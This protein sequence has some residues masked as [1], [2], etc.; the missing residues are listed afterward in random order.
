MR[1]YPVEVRNECGTVKRRLLPIVACV[2]AIAPA[3]FAQ[4]AVA[5]WRIT[6]QA[7]SERVCGSAAAN[8]QLSCLRDNRAL[9]SAPCRFALDSM[10]GQRARL[11]QACAAD[12][13]LYCS[14]I[15]L[16]AAR[17]RCLAANRDQLSDS[18]KAAFARMGSAPPE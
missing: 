4:Q 2:L 3:G 10:L 12:A 16:G 13:G 17:T 9:I 14:G 18:C 8:G 7:D 6:C 5:P 11:R 1:S 15:S